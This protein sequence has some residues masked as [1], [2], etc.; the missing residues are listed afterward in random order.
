[1]LSKGPL[2]TFRADSGFKLNNSNYK[3]AES[4][5]RKLIGK[6]SAHGW[7]FKSNPAHI[8][9]H[10]NQVKFG[11]SK[12]VHES[13]NLTANQASR[14]YLESYEKLHSLGSPDKI[15]KVR[16]ANVKESDVGGSGLDLPTEVVH[17][18]FQFQGLG[19]AYKSTTK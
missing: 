14:D 15:K 19:S 12:I 9:A 1:M 5:E 2:N 4:G 17:H 16:E 3:V 18:N 10:I 7:E 8:K 6:S 11:S 13:H